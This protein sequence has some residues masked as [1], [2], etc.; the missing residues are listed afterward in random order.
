MI[1]DTSTA[2]SH[3]VQVHVHQWLLPF[4]L[5]GYFLSDAFVRT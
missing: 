2:N 5:L 4:H 1:H 3:A